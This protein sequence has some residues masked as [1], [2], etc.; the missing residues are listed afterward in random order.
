MNGATTQLMD[1]RG[2]VEFFYELQIFE[3]IIAQ[4]LPKK[5]LL[6]HESNFTITVASAG[7]AN[8]YP[9]YLTGS[10]CSPCQISSSAEPLFYLLETFV[11]LTR[12]DAYLIFVIFFT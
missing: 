4:T 6:I 11:F 3:G 1:E 9:F 10:F 7:V 2:R 12:V 5:H 8:F